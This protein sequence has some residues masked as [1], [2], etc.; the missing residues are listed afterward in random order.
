MRLR[1]DMN[2]LADACLTRTQVLAVSVCEISNAQRMVMDT[3]AQQF[4]ALNDLV[5]QVQWLTGSDQATKA[6]M[7][8]GGWLY[9]HLTEM[10][11][12]IEK[13]VLNSKV[14]RKET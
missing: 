4:T 8:Q 11:Q 13:W 6:I 1:G 3:Y 10:Q 9:G 2:E 14:W 5:G 12:R 7:E